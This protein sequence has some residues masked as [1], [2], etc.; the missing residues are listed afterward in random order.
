MVYEKEIFMGRKSSSAN[1]E[2]SSDNS[3]KSKKDL[4]NEFMSLKLLKDSP[5]FW[6]FRTLSLSE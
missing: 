3:G 5:S 6:R 4:L 2:G 1:E